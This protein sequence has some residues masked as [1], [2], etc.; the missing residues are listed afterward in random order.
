[1]NYQIL[2]Y[3]IQKEK[4]GMKSKAIYEQNMSNNGSLSTVRIAKPKDSTP[5]ICT[6][7]VELKRFALENLHELVIHFSGN[8]LKENFNIIKNNLYDNNEKDLLF[9]DSTGYAICNLAINQK[10]NLSAR[11]REM[12]YAISIGVNNM[13]FKRNRIGFAVTT[14]K[15]REPQETVFYDTISEAVK[16]IKNCIEQSEKGEIV[17][18]LSTTR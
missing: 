1:M 8:E 18:I 15:D 13:D 14:Y 11:L 7:R 10:D 12:I 9:S 6:I 3:G 2:Q 5:L 17:E 16:T 4:D